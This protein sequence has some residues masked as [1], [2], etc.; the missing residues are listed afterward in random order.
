MTPQEYRVTFRK[1]IRD[2]MIDVIQSDGFRAVIRILDAEEHRRELVRKLFEEIGEYLA[3]G[4]LEELADVYEVIRS[5]ALLDSAYEDTLLA[6]AADKRRR[7]GSFIRGVFLE[8]I[9][10][11]EHARH[12]EE[13]GEAPEGLCRPT[14]PRE[15]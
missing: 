15:K 14:L 3:A 13:I 4:T 11:D 6:T 7:R 5:L 1:L 10:S 8:Y 9:L 12:L 2:N